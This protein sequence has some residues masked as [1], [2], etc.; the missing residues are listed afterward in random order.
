MKLHA[1]GNKRFREDS[2]EEK[3]Y[4]NTHINTSVLI[5]FQAFSIVENWE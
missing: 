2:G 3:M 4:T 1:L 5:G